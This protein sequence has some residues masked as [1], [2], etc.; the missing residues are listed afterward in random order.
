[1]MD[2]IISLLPFSIGSSVIKTAAI[3]GFGI[4]FTSLV[5]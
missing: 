5:N 2:S 1:M 4:S 3:F